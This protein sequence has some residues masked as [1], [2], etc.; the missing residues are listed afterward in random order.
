MKKS[1]FNVFIFGFCFYLIG[2]GTAQAET[3]FVKEPPPEGLDP[4]MRTT[5]V[6]LVKSSVAQEK[7]YSLTGDA[8]NAEIVLIPKVLK[9]GES[10]L[11]TIEKYKG[12]KLVFA[13]K[14]KAANADDLDTVSSRIVRSVLKEIKVADTVT[15]QD[16]TKDEET[17]GTRRYQSTRQWKLAFGPSYGQGLNTTSSS[18]YF[19][20][21]YVWGLDPNFDLQLSW[22]GTYFGG[23]NTF[24]GA[25]FSDFGLGMVYYLSTDKNAFYVSGAIEKASATANQDDAAFLSSD[26]SPFQKRFLFKRTYQFD[27]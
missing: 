17:R 5:V 21:G 22:I 9:L 7:G 23:K 19:E 10:Y 25:S 12:D 2:V 13:T 20:I 27:K 6:E 14:M 1:I 26:I 3:V 15:V 16:V 24:S 8:K 11:F 18:T 4:T